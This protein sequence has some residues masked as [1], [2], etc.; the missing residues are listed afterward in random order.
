MFGIF[1][2]RFWPKRIA[3]RGRLL[4]TKFAPRRTETHTHTHTHTHT[5]VHL[6]TP[7]SVAPN[8]PNLSRFASRRRDPREGPSP[9]EGV[10]I[11]VGLDPADAEPELPELFF[12]EPKAIPFFSGTRNQNT[13]PYMSAETTLN[14]R[15]TSS[16]AERS[17]PQTATTITHLK[18]LSVPLAK[19]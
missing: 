10:Q 11:R 9:A 18:I 12:Q 4:P 7:F 5:S 16:L 8:R 1:L 19:S 6:L 14:Y 13:N 2:G 3:S 17:Q 15:Q